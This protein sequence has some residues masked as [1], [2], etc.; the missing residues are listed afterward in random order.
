MS[1][2]N[3]WDYYPCE[4]TN[5]YG[6]DFRRNIIHTVIDWTLTAYGII[7]AISF[8]SLSGNSAISRSPAST[9]LSPVS[10]RKSGRISAT[11]T[12]RK[13]Y[14]HKSGSYICPSMVMIS[15]SIGRGAFLSLFRTRPSCASKGRKISHLSA[16]ASS[17]VRHNKAAFKKFGPDDPTA[18]L[19]QTEETR[20][21]VRWLANN[22]SAS[23]RLRSG[24]MFDPSNRHI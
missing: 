6:N 10:D 8:L 1:S 5:D 7:S 2:R 4:A 23:R 14:C 24:W 12:A 13:E 9:S 11:G 18:A 19:S 21:M 15:R 3:G 22:P 17:G 20:M 16:S